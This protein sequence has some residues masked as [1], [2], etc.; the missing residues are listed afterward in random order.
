MHK[1]IENK[2]QTSLICENPSYRKH[3]IDTAIRNNNDPVFETFVQKFYSYLPVDYMEPNQTEFFAEIALKSFKFCHNRT[4][5][6]KIHFTH[7]YQSNSCGAPNCAALQIN[8]LDKPF[9]VDSIKGILR[10]AGVHLKIFL[11]PL[12]NI[13]RSSNG[14]ITNISDAGT[15]E[16]II[17]AI[18]QGVTETVA[19]KLEH[20]IENILQK[21]DLVVDSKDKILDTL[22]YLIVNSKAEDKKFL[23]WI[24]SENFIFLGSL[25]YG[26][27]GTIEKIMGDVSIYEKDKPYMEDVIKNAY[28]SNNADISLGKM[29]QIS[30]V[31]T[32][33]FIDYILVPNNNGGNLFF[34]F[35]ASGLYSQSIKTIPMLS[36]K[37]EYVLHRS[38]FKNGA[39]NY[40]K[41][42]Q[43]VESFPREALFQIDQE[44]LY[45]ICLHILSAMLARTLK[46]FIQADSSGELL[47]VLVFMPIE[48]LTPEV[49]L[50]INKYLIAKFN[51][52]IITD[53]IT[54]VSS[55]F[56]YL[57]VTLE[58]NDVM[59]DFSLSDI[60]TELDHLSARWHMSLIKELESKSE[61]V[62]ISE[63][64]FPKEY[65]YLFTPSEGAQD[66]IFIHA[67]GKKH[68]L[69]FNLQKSKNHDYRIKIYSTD[70]I[71][72]SDI[73]PL[74]EN[75]GFKALAEQMFAIDLG[76]T[77]HWLCEFSLSAACDAN[78]SYHTMKEN[79]ED[80]LNYMTSGKLENDVLCKL[81]VLAALNWR[82]VLVLKALTA[83][84]NQIGFAYS[85][86][87]V[88]SVLVKH[89]EFAK[90][91]IELFEA[92]FDPESNS[93]NKASEIRNVLGELLNAVTNNVEDK[94]LRTVWD[95]LEGITRTNFYQ[96][97]K[98]T[99]KPYLSFKFNSH[100]VP[101][102]PL[103]LPYA[104]IF[105]YSNHFEGIHLR[106]GK[107]ARGGIRWSDRIADYRTEAL[108]L[109]KAQMTK[110]S[111]I[112]PVGSKGAFYVKI[113]A[114]GMERKAYLN[115]VIECY[116]N[117]LRGLLDLTDNIVDGKIIPPSDVKIYDDQDPYL[118]VAADKG[119]ATFSDYAN[120]VSAEYSFWL[121]D[122]FA[123]GG[124]AGYDHKKI[125]IT[126][127]GAWISVTRHFVEMGI[128]VQNDNFTVVGIGDMSGDVFGNGMLLSSSLLLVAAFN[129]K[130]IFIDPTPN[131]ITSFK[132]RQRLFDMPGSAWSDYDA[133]LI[134]KGGGVYE[135][136]AKKITLSDEAREILDIG[137]NELSPEELIN[138]I[139][140][141]P[142]DLLWNG[143]IGTYIKSS[144]ESNLDVGDKTNDSVRCNGNEIRAKVIGEG[145][146]LGVSQL[147]RI[148]YAK[149]G[150]KINTDFIDNSA[151]VDCSDHEVNI[152][153]SLGQ[154]VKKGTVSLEERNKL[155]ADMTD[156]I[157]ALVLLD[158]YKQTQALSLLEHSA[159]Y[160]IG[161]FA[162]LMDELED[163]GLLNRAVEFLPNSAEITKRTLANEKLA[164]PELA[165]I[166]SYS[167]MSV[168]NEL[169]SSK[170]AEDKFAETLLVDYFPTMM[171]ERFR[172][173]ILS[174]QL[175]KEIILTALTNK[176]VNQL[177][178]PVIEHII[179][180]TGAKLCDLV[181]AYVIVNQI[182]CID[183]LWAETEKLSGT[184]TSTIQIDMFSE[185]IKLMRRGICWFLRNLSQPIEITAA[186]DKYNL[187]VREVYEMIGSFLLGQARIK[188]ET[189][190]NDYVLGHVPKTLADKIAILDSGISA[191][192]IVTV[193]L[194]TGHNPTEIA[195]LYFKVA[196]R[197]SI[198][199]LRKCAEKQMTDSYW[200][201]MSV[202]AVKDDLYDKQRRL[203]HK[204]LES[205]IELIDL[206][207][208]I[209][210]HT[211]IIQ[212]FTDFIEELHA[213]DT[214]DLNMVILANKQF[215]MLLRKV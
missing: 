101:H 2:A 76:K 61:I 72:L 92:K 118:V 38:G 34:G 107:V 115:E 121:G 141:A 126:A 52:K 56:C 167:K 91:I 181:R 177:G 116:K 210:E 132:E 31:S 15:D 51:T 173:E 143:G 125:A 160:N 54:D 137:S 94:V 48:R 10:R 3:I 202:Q 85:K 16:S 179:A 98:E 186:V 100:K 139:L 20:D 138:K 4:D 73:L 23:Q 13:K 147:G 135:R 165:V 66:L 35:Y 136:S 203:L 103:P 112:V 214:V 29:N 161:M 110:N 119:T 162:K 40:R 105:V 212:I 80:A 213:Q 182:F 145:G 18:L 151:G 1:Y 146:N 184:V 206:D 189:K 5:R 158:N 28:T 90:L 149:S 53:E 12:M 209:A 171:K 128:D 93:S 11:H 88:Q 215:E 30:E 32:G 49:H 175:R 14:D 58:T 42:Q 163:K 25:K 86:D 22:N 134:S 50:A 44:D 170:I 199:W 8:T 69:L 7:N 185:L 104:E 70:K 97:S 71:I 83:Y 120:S 37:L 89:Y 41:L 109:M 81:I 193:S 75:L 200:N 131:A 87:Y 106:G 174:H 130:H 82:Q 194:A 140:K 9:I 46:L 191:L 183:D 190:I 196:D 117:F 178:G 111:V 96:M 60:E 153:I 6:N 63:S 127:R 192:D 144:S 201:R 150:G 99:Y 77:T 33:K 123:S 17:F 74:I 95:A 208:W 108:G 169:L 68:N 113:N 157:A 187:S 142:V 133:K 27:D 211:K 55:S 148:E 57:Y 156:D 21:I 176:I 65:Q 154:A 24:E 43:I 67:L 102:L 197:F 84:I 159:A 152:K 166:L 26:V 39:Y 79:I 124:S 19:K 180:D 195:E 122:A 62:G 168:Y 64:T 59:P 129:H 78:C 114:D 198:D 207:Q 45:C 172:D 36:H 155:L 164:R 205:S 47:N 204:V 188:L